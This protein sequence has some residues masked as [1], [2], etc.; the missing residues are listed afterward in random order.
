MKAFLTCLFFIIISSFSYWSYEHHAAPYKEKQEGAEKKVQDLLKSIPKDNP[1]K[2]LM[3]WLD[4]AKILF[5]EKR[6]EEA[7]VYLQKILKESPEQVDVQYSEAICYKA[8]KMTRDSM[9]SFQ[10]VLK[11]KSDHLG[12]MEHLVN[13]FDKDEYRLTLAKLAYKKK[14]YPLALKH[15]QVLRKK[16][17]NNPSI[18]LSF[19][20]TQTAAGQKVSAIQTFGEIQ[21]AY[22]EH[23]NILLTAGQMLVSLKAYDQAITCFKSILKKKPNHAVAV[24]ELLKIAEMNKK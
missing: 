14:D 10:K 18:H 21:K 15:Y 23:I 3:I 8:M 22:P 17:P 1:N 9:K 5:E 4:V 6:Y 11:L 7:L 19:A 20:I 16:L 2:K 12:A 13:H 24:D